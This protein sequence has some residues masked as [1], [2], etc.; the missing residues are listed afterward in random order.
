[1]T[2]KTLRA[3]QSDRDFGRIAIQNELITEEQLEG[4]LEA[5]ERLLE[6]VE[7]SGKGKKKVRKPRLVDVLV[8]KELLD[9]KQAASVE[10]ARR[11]REVRLADKLYGRIALKSEFLKPRAIER[12]LEAQ[13]KAYVAGK[14]EVRLSAW[15][16]AKEHLTEEQDRA[17]SD[18][19]KELDRD[20]Y[21]PC[22]VAKPKGKAETEEAAEKIEVEELDLDLELASD[23]P[24]AKADKQPKAKSESE[25]LALDDDDEL[26]DVDSNIDLDLE[27]L[28]EEL[29][30]ISES[31]AAKAKPAAKKASKKKA[32]SDEELELALADSDDA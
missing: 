18:A 17:V 14:D 16:V 15:L 1:V 10:K 32:A 31:S 26:A 13:K 24:K 27:G 25:P 21:L 6:K 20:E 23:E 4:A 5:L 11:Y 7:G 30:K 22:R 19:M 8:Q 9:G 12:A 29:A 2:E 28:D 3:T